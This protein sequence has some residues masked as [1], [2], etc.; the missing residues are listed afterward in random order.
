MSQLNYEDSVY[1]S[2]ALW[3]MESDY[4][5]TLHFRSLNQK[6]VDFRDG[7]IHRMSAAVEMRQ[8][9]A[10]FALVTVVIIL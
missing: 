4:T 1:G 6:D 10:D 5:V 3:C 8:A 2:A 9:A 7:D